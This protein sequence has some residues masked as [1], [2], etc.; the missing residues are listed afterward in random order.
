MIW[1]GDIDEY[2]ELLRMA[3]FI[4]ADTEN[5]GTVNL[6][7]LWN[8]THYGTG[9][10]TAIRIDPSIVYSYYFPF[11]HESDNLGP[12]ILARLRP[13]LETT[14]LGFHN[15]PIDIAT[16]ETFGITISIPPKDS[17]ILAHFVN[18]EFPSKELEW[19]SKFVLKME[20]HKDKVKQWAA[21]WGYDTIPV[22]LMFPYA[23]M[24]AEKQLYLTEVFWKDMEP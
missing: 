4:G 21:I 19:L 7:E 12:E 3:D 14:E 1:E 15:A 11:R 5:S 18:E 9:I 8:G 6:A 16:C 20:H 17:I 22:K 13:I 10:S 24:D 2:I 23:C